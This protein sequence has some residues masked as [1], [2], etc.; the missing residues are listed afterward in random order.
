MFG[1]EGCGVGADYADVG[2]LPSSDAVDGSFVV[3]V[4]PFYAE[5][6]YFGV[7]A[8]LVYEESSL[9]RSDLDVQ[10]GGASENIVEIETGREVFG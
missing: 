3:L 9:S 2:D 10:G 1:E 8:G 4:C 7:M 6:V 5:E